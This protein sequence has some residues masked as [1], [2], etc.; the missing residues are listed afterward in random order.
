MIDVQRKFGGKSA[1]VDIDCREFLFSLQ[2]FGEI[3]HSMEVWLMR[4]V[5]TSVV[6]GMLFAFFAGASPALA[7]RVVGG[8]FAPAN[9]WLQQ[10]NLHLTESP[11]EAVADG[12][13]LVAGQGLPMA[14]GSSAQQRMTALRAAE[15]GAYRRLAEII[16][17]VHV[18]GQTTVRDCAL[19][20][21]VVKSAVSGLV[22]GA[23]KVFEE[24]NP[25]EGSAVVL[26]QVG[27]RGADS[28][29]QT[30]YD[31]YL[32]AASGRALLQTAV[33]SPPVLPTSTESYDGL[34]IDAR[35]LAFQ[36][37][38]INRIFT[39]KGEAVY[40]A[41]KVSQKILVEHG[42]GE[43]TNSIEKARA[44]LETRGVKAPMIVKASG[45]KSMAD[46]QVSDDD[47]LRIHSADRKGN[48]LAAARVAFVLR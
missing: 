36:P 41:S 17:G 15:I 27:V 9:A 8:E 13:I 6:W 18:S 14:G 11:Q 7:D 34:I 45:L 19:E 46:L 30:L 2:V 10:R 22:K 3:E 43:Y 39:L 37:A 33:Y 26:L 35:E 21:D 4:N 29:A 48:F 24:W 40:D 23:R 1:P 5:T 44:A 28:V 42:A 16:N 47:V 31:K 20:N 12:Y 38:L 25:A 32:N